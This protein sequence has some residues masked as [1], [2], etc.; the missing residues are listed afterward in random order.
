[1]TNIKLRQIA[2]VGDDYDG[3]HHQLSEVF[4]LVDGYRDPG[5]RSFS[6]GGVSGFGLRNFVMPI[7][8]EFLE[9]V[10]PL[11]GV[12]DSAGARFIDRRGGAG[13]YM[14][15]MQVPRA[16]FAAV[17][18]RVADLGIRL[19]AGED[20]G[21][22]TSEAIHLHPKDLPGV[23]AEFR[24]CDDED[25]SDGDWWPVE[26]TWREAKRTQVIDSIR[27][28]EIQTPEPEVLAARWAEVLDVA[29]AHD[30]GHPC[31]NLANGQIRFVVPADG[32]PEGLGGIDLGTVDREAALTAAERAGCAVDGDTVLLCGTRMRLVEPL[33][34]EHLGLERRGEV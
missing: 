6:D 19:A 33:G 13:G 28:A 34:L 17:R 18:A 31:V 29:V 3:V 21:D 7:G 24:W 11:P 20:I 27:G 1:M 26:K 32:R 15:L 8:N 16:E 22:G 14:I 30:E 9:L 4:G 25:E 12:D 23:I 2:L 10:S 5:D